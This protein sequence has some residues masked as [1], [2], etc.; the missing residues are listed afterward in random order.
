MPPGIRFSFH[1][2]FSI[3]VEGSL[4]PSERWKSSQGW[5][6]SFRFG[7]QLLPWEFRAKY[8]LSPP[9]AAFRHPPSEN[10]AL[11]YTLLRSSSCRFTSPES[12][13]SL[14]EKCVQG[15]IMLV[16]FSRATRLRTNACAFQQPT[17]IDSETESRDLSS[18]LMQ[19]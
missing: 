16:K 2:T 11:H 10:Q 3:C 1:K 19:R 4:P 7:K 12:L 8:E 17:A 15:Q 6:V 5:R 9:R 14:D 13:D 18:R